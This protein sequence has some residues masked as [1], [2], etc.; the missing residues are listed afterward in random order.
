MGISIKDHSVREALHLT[1][2]YLSYNSPS[3]VCFLTKDELLA[4]SDSEEYRRFIEEEADVTMIATSDIF[5]AANVEEKGRAREIDRNLY[6]KGLLHLLSKERRRIYL[7]TQT[8]AH[9]SDLK[10]LLGT[11][12]S[13]LQIAG[14]C[15]TADIS[16]AEDVTNDIN[17][18]TP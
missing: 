13:A 2:E 1:R 15:E 12:E 6:L 18:V 8:A 5:K 14:A 9:M 4:A 16:A 10:N 11:F 17:T 7:L 3:V